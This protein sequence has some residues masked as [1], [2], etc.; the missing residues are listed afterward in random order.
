VGRIPTKRH[1]PSPE[2]LVHCVRIFIP[3]Y[4]VDTFAT[5]KIS[6]PIEMHSVAI[7]VHVRDTQ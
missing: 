1:C 6:Y 7:L 4:C 5:C 2:I 3:V